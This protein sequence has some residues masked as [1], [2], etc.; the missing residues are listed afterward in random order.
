MAKTVEGGFVD[1]IKIYEKLKDLGMNEHDI[2]KVLELVKPIYSTI[3]S[4]FHT[5]M[6]N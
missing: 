3:S 2:C 1:S 4:P 6:V 5:S